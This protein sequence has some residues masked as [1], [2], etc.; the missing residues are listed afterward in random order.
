MCNILDRMVLHMI[1]CTLAA[2]LAQRG[3]K[4]TKV[5]AD[6]GISRTTLTEIVAGRNKGVYLDTLNTLCRYLNVK[7][8][9][10]FIYSPI[11]IT[12]QGIYLPKAEPDE[13]PLFPKVIEAAKATCAPLVLKFT[14]EDPNEAEACVYYYPIPFGTGKQNQAS[15]KL[16]IDLRM[17][18]DGSVIHEESDKDLRQYFAMLPIEISKNLGQEVF[19]AAFSLFEDWRMDKCGM[20]ENPFLSKPQLLWPEELSLQGVK[21]WRQ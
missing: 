12:V 7:P 2:L 15:E 3:L 19:S 14:V 11:D 20:T 8:G 10:F 5:S 4:I 6:T 16:V 13:N 17:R 21:T 18:S 1:A 9:E